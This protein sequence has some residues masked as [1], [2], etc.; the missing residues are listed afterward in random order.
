MLAFLRQLFDTDGF[1]ARW[2][3]GSGWTNGLGWLH[4]V[5]DLL[6]WSAYFTIPLILIYFASQ[7][8]DLPFRRVF[9]L[10]GA[11]ILFCGLTHLMDAVIFW[12]PAYRFAGILKLATAIVSWGTVIALIPVLPQALSLRSPRQLEGQI[13]DRTRELVAA[14]EALTNE[15]EKRKEVEASLREQTE[16]LLR[17]EEQLRLA[18]DAGRMGTWDWNIAAGQL[19]WTGQLEEI[20]GLAP[21]TFAG[22]F[23][24]FMNCVHPGDRAMLTAEIQ[25]A[26][27]NRTPFDIEFRNPWPDGTLHWVGGTGRAVYDEAGQ[28]QRMI[29]IGYDVTSRKHA[30]QSARFLAHASVILA[31]VSEPN[32]T[33]TNLAQLAV[34]EFA[35][36]CAIDLLTNEGVLKRVAVAHVDPQKIE[37]AHELHAK[38][39][40]HPDAPRGVWQ[41][42]RS[43]ES[44]MVATITPEMVTASVADAEQLEAIM[45]LGLHSYMCVP[46]KAGGETFGTVSFITAESRRTYTETDILM[47]EDLARRAAIAIENARLYSDLREADRRKDEFLA[48]LAHELRNPLAPIGNALQI[49]EMTKSPTEVQQ[50]RGMMERQ[51][52]HLVRLVDDLLDISR[53]RRGKIELRLEPT[54]LSSV[55]ERAV[56]GARPLIAAQQ[57]ELIVELPPYPVELV[58]DPVRITQVI[59]N[60]LTNAAKY[61][62]QGGRIQLLTTVNDR[63]VCIAVRDNG[64]GIASTTLPHVFEIFMQVEPTDQRTQGGLGIGLM[65]V[66]SLCE[67]HGGRVEARSAGPG[68]GS[69]FLVWLP[70]EQSLLGATAASSRSSISRGDP[71]PRRILIVDDNVDAAKTLARV[72]QAK[73]HAVE[74]AHDGP[75][76]LAQFALSRPEVVVL[77]LG[78]PGMDGYE[79]A[80]RLRELVEGDELTLIAL[81]G[82][83][84]VEDRKRTATVGFD[85]HLVKPV[86]LAVLEAIIA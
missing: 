52:R 72:L 14:N 6:V 70:R 43:G 41:V 29:G 12:W 68:Q 75:S 36:W 8:R 39:P 27:Q 18:L 4:I 51:F 26:L 1:P 74:V 63:E 5:S 32:T 71:R 53:I 25:R 31:E 60:L 21:G 42:L 20:H 65:L 62:D 44:E 57:H 16:K 22:T 58:V 61:T 67:M 73:Q 28:P 9:L 50:T 69:E 83:S 76:A 19:H 13:E 34:P 79:V 85:Q 45:A 35:D 40:P 30:E 17:S 55:V 3:C 11:F 10:F 24:S 77:D 47:A 80:G 56:E 38:Y 82:W 59:F 37:L 66:R 64:I 2:N 78:M 81:T 84:S 49:L 23:E 15:I 7:R 33:L 46:L 86:D 54:P 48:I